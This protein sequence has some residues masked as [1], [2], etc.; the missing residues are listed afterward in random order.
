[1]AF[2]SIPFIPTWDVLLIFFFLASGFFYGLLF[3]RSRMLAF[4]V[5]IYIGIACASLPL[6]AL[7]SQLQNDAREL[8]FVGVFIVCTFV[9]H[10]V[11]HASLLQNRRL[12]NE[13]W[14]QVFILSFLSLGLVASVIG[15]LL[16]SSYHDLFTETTQFFF[17]SDT[18]YSTWFFLPL[19]ALLF[20]SKKVE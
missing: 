9:S 2:P 17:F 5:S 10:F 8:F 7:Q 12:G 11:L 1:M 14:W 15:R 3:G 13:R 4:T 19:V 6:D 20:G 18:A 16:P